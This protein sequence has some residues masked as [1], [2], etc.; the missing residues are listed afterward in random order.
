MIARL[1]DAASHRK[2]IIQDLEL[3]KRWGYRDWMLQG[4]TKPIPGIGDDL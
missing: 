1:W 2:A 3:K 4:T